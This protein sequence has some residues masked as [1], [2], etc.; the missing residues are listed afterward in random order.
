MSFAPSKIHFF[1]FRREYPRCSPRPEAH[2]PTKRHDDEENEG[3][4]AE[5][6]DGDLHFSHPWSETNQRVR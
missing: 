4:Q 5:H 6:R 2:K 1:F 3:C